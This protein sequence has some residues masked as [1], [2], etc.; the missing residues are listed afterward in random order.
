MGPFK[1][2]FYNFFFSGGFL[3]TC[4]SQRKKS[5]NLRGKAPLKKE[6]FDNG[7]LDV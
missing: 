4:F 3:L 5:W 7:L 6:F 1:T 2:N